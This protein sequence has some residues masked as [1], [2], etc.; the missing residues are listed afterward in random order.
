[1]ER[2]KI[3]EEVFD[4]ADEVGLDREDIGFVYLFGS[5]V[6]SPETARDI[7]ICISADVD[8]PQQLEMELDGRVPEEIDVSVFE[9][10]PLHVRKQVFSGE[11]LY[12]RDDLAYDE[13][14]ETF[15]DF[16]SF[17]PLYRTAIGG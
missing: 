4:A 9:A 8:N 16:E 5:Y 2:E 17:E 14:F 13:A 10:L 12:S 6:D 15:R 3:L 7:D 11:L 1:M